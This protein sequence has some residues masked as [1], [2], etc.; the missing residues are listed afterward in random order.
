MRRHLG[1]GRIVAQGREEQLGQAHAAK[2]TGTPRP[3][4]SRVRRGRRRR[5]GRSR[6]G[7]RRLR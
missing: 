1:F 2:D 6:A 3:L 4:V 7:V 5:A